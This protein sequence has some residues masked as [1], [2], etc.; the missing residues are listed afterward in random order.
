MKQIVGQEI[1]PQFVQHL[2][3]EEWYG[4]SRLEIAFF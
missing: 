4:Q 2:F 3:N 1:F